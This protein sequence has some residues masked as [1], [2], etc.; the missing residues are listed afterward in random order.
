MDEIDLGAWLPADN[1]ETAG[2]KPH[3]GVLNAYKLRTGTGESEKQGEG[4]GQRMRCPYRMV[5]E[6]SEV[7]A[8]L[9][10]VPEEL[11]VDFVM[12][13]NFRRFHKRA[14]LSRAPICRGLLQVGVAILYVFS[15]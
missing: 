9:K 8:A 13:L 6:I 12:V 7:R 2:P 10:H 3:G 15:E 11:I 5:Q 4:T 1:A 14:E